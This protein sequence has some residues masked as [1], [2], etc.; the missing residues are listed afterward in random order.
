MTKPNYTDALE[1][2]LLE[3]IKLNAEVQ[4]AL[5]QANKEIARLQM[6]LSK[7]KFSKLTNFLSA[8]SNA[9][10]DNSALVANLKELKE[11]LQTPTLPET[12]ATTNP[13]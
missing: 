7:A 2:Q 6:E 3:Q 5:I 9:F 13:E 1:K 10:S 12:D 4:I 8:F 11:T